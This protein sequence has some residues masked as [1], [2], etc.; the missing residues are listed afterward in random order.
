MD[1][2]WDERY[3]PTNRQPAGR[4]RTLSACVSAPCRETRAVWPFHSAAAV[5]APYCHSLVQRGRRWINLAFLDQ[6]TNRSLLSTSRP[7][8]WIPAPHLVTATLNRALK[9]DLRLVTPRGPQALSLAIPPANTSLCL[10]P[11]N[12]YIPDSLPLS[13]ILLSVPLLLSYS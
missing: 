4:A 10:V 1:T 6:L 11:G 7:A 3:A 5:P 12:P 2:Y 9:D 8:P 13:F